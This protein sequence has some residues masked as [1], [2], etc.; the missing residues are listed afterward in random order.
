MPNLEP[1]SSQMEDTE[2]AEEL[3]GVQCLP[4]SCGL[5]QALL[6]W[7]DWTIWTLSSLLDM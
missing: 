6:R 5:V 7:T 3:C 2:T 1:T 4:D